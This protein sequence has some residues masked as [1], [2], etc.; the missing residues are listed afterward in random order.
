MPAITSLNLSRALRLTNAHILAALDATGTNLTRLDLSRCP[1]ITAD[2]CTTLAARP[3]R[4]LRLSWT[5]IGSDGVDTLIAAWTERP[6]LIANLDDV[7][8]AGLSLVPHT[9][10]DLMA[11]FAREWHRRAVDPKRCRMRVDVSH[12][13]QMSGARHL[14]PAWVPHKEASLHG[15]D[16]N[17][18]Y[19]DGVYGGDV[20]V[21]ERA[22]AAV[23]CSPWVVVIPAAEPVEKVGALMQ[24]QDVA[25]T[26][27]IAAERGWTGLLSD[28]LALAPTGAELTKP[29]DVGS[30]ID[31][32]GLPVGVEAD[33][34]AMPAVAEAAGGDVL[35]TSATSESRPRTPVGGV[36]LDGPP[37]A[38]VQSPCAERI[39]V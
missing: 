4:S 1:N 38:V 29:V 12:T 34:T 19:C 20:A 6:D 17:V 21:L 28:V 8:L 10:Q 30:R 35:S 36:D 11:V 37:A 23:T 18:A 39:T 7:A 24:G 26:A 25:T 27:S 16:L 32:A 5:R 9:V 33:A 22:G 15:L 3:W 14:V 2:L 31:S 13:M